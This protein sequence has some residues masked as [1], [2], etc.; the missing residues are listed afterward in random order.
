MQIIVLFSSFFSIA[1]KKQNQPV[2]TFETDQIIH[3]FQNMCIGDI[4]KVKSNPILQ[5]ST[6][7]ARKAIYR[8]GMKIRFQDI[9]RTAELEAAYPLHIAALMVSHKLIALSIVTL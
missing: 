7:F 1:L 8:W 4:Q 2:N 6:N 9:Y 3:L 5:D